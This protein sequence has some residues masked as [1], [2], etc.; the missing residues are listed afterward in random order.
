VGDIELADE[1]VALLPP[2]APP[3]IYDLLI[4][5]QTPSGRWR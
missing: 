1:E 2:S 5:P 4:P 3:A